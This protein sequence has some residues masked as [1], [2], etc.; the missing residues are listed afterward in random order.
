[1][2]EMMCSI[3]IG[4]SSDECLTTLISV[5]LHP[6]FILEGSSG[7][8][9]HVKVTHNRFSAVFYH[10]IITGFGDGLD[11]RQT[12]RRNKLHLQLPKEG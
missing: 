1:M 11:P 3:E 12:T 2:I 10:T 9:S 6:A 5:M 7:I 8:A 4:L